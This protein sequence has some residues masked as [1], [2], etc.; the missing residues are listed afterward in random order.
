MDHMRK[1]MAA[2]KS[3]A[4]KGS[5]VQSYCLALSAGMLMVLSLPMLVLSLQPPVLCDVVSVGAL[6]VLGA[7]LSTPVVVLVVSCETAVVSA[8]PGRWPMVLSVGVPRV[9][10]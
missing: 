8:A 1:K 4:A 6:P 5:T 3:E 7:V 10:S 2:P 9:L